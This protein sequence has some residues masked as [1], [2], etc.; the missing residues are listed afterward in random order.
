MFLQEGIANLLNKVLEEFGGYKMSKKEGLSV[1]ELLKNTYDRLAEKRPHQEIV[2]PHKTLSEIANDS[3]GHR[4]KVGYMGYEKANLFQF[5][6]KTWAVSRGEAWGGYPADPYNS[7]ILAI[8]IVLKKEIKGS[9]FRKKSNKQLAD[10]IIKAIKRGSYLGNS[11]ICGMADGQLT[12]SKSS[13]FGERILELLRQKTPNYIAQE[14]ETRSDM[15]QL[16][17]RPV[18]EKEMRY[19]SEFVDYLTM[20]I[21]SVLKNN[22]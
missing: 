15:T 22:Q 4:T 18:V 8:E 10:D 7:D 16:D 9:K 17:L 21:E 13:P 6:G 20:A 1:G 11:L 2:L 12:V 3:D 14:L 5:N 19:K